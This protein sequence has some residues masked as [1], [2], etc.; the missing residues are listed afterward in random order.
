[1]RRERQAF[2]CYINESVKAV[3]VLLD[4]SPTGMTAFV[5]FMS[6]SAEEGKSTLGLKS[7]L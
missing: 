6:L 2:M 1:M 5:K 4:A 3:I 7:G